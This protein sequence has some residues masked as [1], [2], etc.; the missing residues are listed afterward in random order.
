M[1]AKFLAVFMQRMSVSNLVNEKVFLCII[2]FVYVSC[3][4][5]CNAFGDKRNKTFIV[6]LVIF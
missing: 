2:K 5:Y 6:K 3:I 4:L 1:C